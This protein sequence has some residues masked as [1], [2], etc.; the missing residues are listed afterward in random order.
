M[1][2]SYYPPVQTQNIT[3]PPISNSV[4]SNQ[5]PNYIQPP[6]TNNANYGIT[7]PQQAALNTNANPQTQKTEPKNV[8]PKTLSIVLPKSHLL[9]KRVQTV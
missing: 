6:Q 2:N 8:Q 5:A 9:K 7:T 4:R 1:T 3:Q